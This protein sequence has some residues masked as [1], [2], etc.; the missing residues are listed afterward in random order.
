MLKY[1]FANLWNPTRLWGVKCAKIV[2]KIALAINVAHCA[3]YAG[4]L[5]NS[6]TL[7]GG[8][9]QTHNAVMDCSSHWECRFGDYL[10]NFAYSTNGSA[11]ST[12][13]LNATLPPNPT[14][15]NKSK[16]FFIGTMT[17]NPHSNLI[18]QDFDS[19]N[20]G[21]ALYIN[22]G[23]LSFANGDFATL[24]NTNISVTNAG[25]LGIIGN[26]FTNR[27][28]M[29]A[30]NATISIIPTSARNYGN[31][32]NDNG[33]I[34]IGAD[35]FNIGQRGTLANTFSSVAHITN[36]GKLTIEGNLYNGGQENP[37]ILCQVGGCGGGNI[38]NNGGTI[39]IQ[40]RLISE[41]KDGQ[42]SAVSIY[43]GTLSATGGVQNLS[44]ST[45]TIGAYKGK[46]GKIES[47]VENQGDF[48]IDALGANE[49][50]H[51]LITGNLS[52]NAPS[53]KN[54][55]SD[56]AN[57]TLGED[58]KTL[59]I[60]KHSDKIDNFKISLD[61][62]ESATL[63]A[64]GDGIYNISGAN[65]T[66]LK[67]V[68][69]AIN[70]A[71]FSTFYATP[72]AMIDTL[73][74]DI[75]P[76]SKVTTRQKSH[77]KSQSRK[78]ATRQKSQ[79]HTKSQTRQ[80]AIHQ[81]R[82]ATN[83]NPNDI[84]AEFIL[85]GIAAN[86]TEGIL[87]GA[88]VG[89]GVDF[90]TMRF[91]LDAAYAYGSVDGVAKGDIAT[92]KTRTQS[93]NFALRSNLNMRFVR[94]FGMDLGL[95]GAIALSNSSRRVESSAI[96]VDST[97]KSAQNLYQITLNTT[98]LYDF[99]IRNFVITPYFGAIQGY[100]AMPHFAEKGGGAFALSA[101][102]YNAYFLDA[103]VGAKTNFDFGE[104]GA[105][106]TDLEY[107]ILAYRTQGE[108]V[109]RYG[110]GKTLRFAIPNTHKISVDLGYH[111]DF[112][113]WYLRADGSFSAF[114]NA[115]N[116]YVYGISAKFGWRF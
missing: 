81:V 75:S 78:V 56:F 62:N 34:T 42:N 66:N 49:G 86:G 45:L 104:Y 85:K 73:N 69:N 92:H 2:C 77:Q 95:G 98:F 28:N 112:N 59:S 36:S 5:P 76:K 44:G 3:N 105:I 68:A 47:N 72:L 22:G 57:A 52:G 16:P 79:T 7:N 110:N 25:K 21:S 74:A 83:A 90:A 51:T 10:Y 71:I 116:F 6:I 17:I 58:Y 53:L 8:E 64:F 1:Y 109:L 9:S 93:H 18:L 24:F 88:K 60:V 84:N 4:S 38:I 106:L 50:N 32:T 102:S 40:G 113:R 46:M 43:G 26:G 31:I 82:K 111:K 61:A 103:L 101:E 65:S 114:I 23:T 108:R 63:G 33:E 80:R 99:R 12:L 55:N 54:G 11:D 97:P 70:S 35:L 30:Q 115:K 41:P 20:L 39:T 87:G 15:Q 37:A 48:I 27:G 14:S 107:K 29:S 96:G 89:Y 67:A 94:D 19:F 91:S 13:T 100:I